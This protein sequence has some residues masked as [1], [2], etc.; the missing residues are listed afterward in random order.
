MPASGMAILVRSVTIRTLP[1]AETPT[2][3]PITMPSITAT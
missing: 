3:P 1:W 2:P